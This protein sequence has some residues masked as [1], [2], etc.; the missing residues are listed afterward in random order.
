MRKWGALVII[1]ALLTSFTTP[2]NAAVD[3]LDPCRIQASRGQTVS[4]G[5][6]FRAERLKFLPKVKIL[7]IPFKLKDNPN[8]VF[9]EDFKA[10]YQR[11]AK[12]ITEFSS[13][14]TNVEFVF[15]PTVSTEFTNSTMNELKLNQQRAWQS[16]EAKS[17]FGFIRKFIADQDASVNYTGIDAVVIQGS[18]TSFES[19]IAEAMMFWRNPD[20]PWFRPI[21]TA[22][23][24]INN[25]V[26]FDNHSNTQTIAHEVMHLYGLTDLY[27]SSTGPGRLSL[28]AS[29]ELNLLTYEKWVLGWHPNQDVKCFSNLSNASTTTFTFD[30]TKDYQLAVIRS[31]SGKDYILETTK[32]R[33]S[34]YLA[35]YSIDNEGRPPLRLFQDNIGNRLDGVLLENYSVIG[36]Q[37]V[38]PDFTLLVSDYSP[39]SISFTL[40]ASAVTSSAEF[41]ESI[42]KAGVAKSNAQKAALE[43][44]AKQDAEAK[45]AEELVAKQRAEVK[46]AEELKAKQEADA[47]AGQAAAMKKTTITCVKGKTT[48]KVTAVKPKCPAGYKRK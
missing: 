20:N 44:K 42:S 36:S 14:T 48:K 40:A 2:V 1:G 15:A 28:M 5:F 34:K 31:S 23:G 37:L 8:Y 22:E 12:I 32:N 26:L 45:A 47:K 30:N 39:T 17:T 16:D 3:E 19:D 33:L 21:E 27:G 4:L 11:A 43:L 25:V 9:T 18:S 7:V 41:K 29:N 6:P 24:S 38:S 13:N 46:A 10:D 35:F